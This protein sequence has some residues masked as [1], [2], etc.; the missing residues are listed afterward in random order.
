MKDSKFKQENDKYTYEEYVRDPIAC[1][2]TLI[3]KDGKQYYT[4]TESSGT[5]IRPVLTPEERAKREQAIINTLESIYRE[6]LQTDPELADQ[7][8]SP[9]EEC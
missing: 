9:S 3:E 5:I 1:G 7:L 6:L 8:T 4:K 2:Y